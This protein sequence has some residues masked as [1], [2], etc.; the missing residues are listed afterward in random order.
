MKTLPKMQVEFI[1]TKHIDTVA[2]QSKSPYKNLPKMEVKEIGF[3]K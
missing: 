3:K 1:K 2:Y